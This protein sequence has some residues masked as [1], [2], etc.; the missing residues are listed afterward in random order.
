MYGCTRSMGMGRALIVCSACGDR[1]NYCA[2]E[3]LNWVYEEHRDNWFCALCI[4]QLFPFNHI[5][6]EGEF[7][8]CI[9]S[10]D[11]KPT[12]VFTDQNCLSLDLFSDP[13]CEKA[14]SVYPDDNFFLNRLNI[15]ACLL[16]SFGSV[17]KI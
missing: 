9:C 3:V 17:W 10:S 1:P 6:E 15:S 8:A 13:I 12:S 11:S 14:A 2:C 4:S 5:T 7:I 16:H